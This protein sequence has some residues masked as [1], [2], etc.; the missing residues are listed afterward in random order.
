MDKSL[1]I[2]RYNE[3]LEWLNKHKDFKITVY[4]KGKS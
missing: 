3:N 1:I 2:A 4:N